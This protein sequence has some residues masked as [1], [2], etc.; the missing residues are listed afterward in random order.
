M[1]TVKR[2]QFTETIAAPV[3]TV[4]ER[5]LALETYRDWTSA[6]AEGSTYEGSWQQGQR[7]R[8]MGPSGDGMLAEIAEHRPNAFV[9][10]RHLGMIVDGVE[11]TTS[12]A[13]RAW[14]PAYENYTF[15][16]TEDGGTRL[17]IDQDVSGDF[18]DYLREAWP[19]ALARLKAICEAA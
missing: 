7:I 10:I 1:S 5:M 19:K 8:F 15:H 18:E 3:E 2:L 16:R 9:S 6:F 12:E 17:V 11:D 4:F 14:T 13:V